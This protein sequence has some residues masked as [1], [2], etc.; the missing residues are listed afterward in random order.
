MEFGQLKPD[1]RQRLSILTKE[2]LKSSLPELALF[3]VTTRI[4]LRISERSRA[5]SLRLVERLGQSAARISAAWR[6]CSHIMLCVSSAA[7][8]QKCLIFVDQ[9]ERDF[10]NRV[11]DA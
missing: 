7:A 3:R 4:M 11:V 10:N 2:A 9:N 1:R 5:S 8:S 6:P